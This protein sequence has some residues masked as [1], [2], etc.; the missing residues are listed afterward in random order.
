MHHY[1]N[2]HIY[3]D[4]CAHHATAWVLYQYSNKHIVHFECYSDAT[5]YELF[6]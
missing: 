2:E 3:Y 1:F 4:E 5:R 6:L